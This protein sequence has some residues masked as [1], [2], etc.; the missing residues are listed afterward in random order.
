FI[1][2]GLMAMFIQTQK[3]FRGSLKQT[4]VLGSG[5][6]IMD[7]ISRELSQMTPSQMARTINFSAEI[8]ASLNPPNSPPF[9]EVGAAGYATLR[10]GMPGTRLGPNQDSRTN[11]MQRIFFLTLVNQDWVGTGYEVIADQPGGLP[12]AGVGTLYRF[13]SSKRNSDVPL[14]AS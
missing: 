14:M 2:L 13:T 5:R 11:V 12:N 10:Q 7:M 9:A 1:I 8:P 4:D 3:A 6:T